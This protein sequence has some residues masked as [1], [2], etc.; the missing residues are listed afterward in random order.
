[1][2]PA[3]TLQVI[4]DCCKIAIAKGYKEADEAQDIVSL[5][6][7]HIKAVCPEC[8]GTG[9]DPETGTTPP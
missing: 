9:H 3:P 8:G 6:E 4:A 2:F 5:C 1:M 7:T